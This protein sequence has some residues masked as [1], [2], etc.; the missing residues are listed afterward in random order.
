MNPRALGVLALVT[1]AAVVAAVNLQWQRDAVLADGRRGELFVPGLTARTNELTAL[2][3]TTPGWQADFRRSGDGFVDKS[4]YPVRL[5]TVRDLVA[6]L[7]VLVTEEAKTDKPARHAELDLLE[8]QP[9]APSGG[10]PQPA[11]AKAGVGKRISLR[12]GEQSVLDL[13]IGKREPSVGGT[14]GGVYARRHGDDATWLLRGAVDLPASRAAWFEN[15]VL[16]VPGTDILSVRLGPAQDQAV[17]E[18]PPGDEP[19]LALSNPPEGGEPD[20]ARIRQLLQ[21]LAT[22]DFADVRKAGDTPAGEPALTLVT[23]EG[24]QVRLYIVGREAKDKS[25]WVRIEADAASGKAGEALATLRERT[26]GF[27]FLFSAQDAAVIGWSRKNLLS[28]G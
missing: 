25:V 8:P 9:G 13:V 1:V 24:L 20:P 5:D 19:R 3:V 4:G 27:E 7:A 18:R 23:L 11:A 14:R 22:L 6:S 15:R 28:L 17:L 10:Q 2:T 12:V 16:A 21:T 26:Q